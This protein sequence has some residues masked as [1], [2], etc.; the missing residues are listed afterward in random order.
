MTLKY[1][2]TT[3]IRDNLLIFV[4]DPTQ[5]E[6]TTIERHGTYVEARI[7]SFLRRVYAFPLT[8]SAVDPYLTELVVDLTTARLLRRYFM[9][10]PK[11]SETETTLED[12]VRQRLLDI[13]P[14]KNNILTVRLSYNL[15]SGY[16]HKPDGKLVIQE[17]WQDDDF[18]S[19]GID[20]ETDWDDSDNFFKMDSQFG[21][22]P[23]AVVDL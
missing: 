13:I 14:N 23:D 20:V 8:P 12:D 5:L 4:K 10:T 15:R 7:D 16:V 9:Q 21:D 17:G 11:K 6:D 19:T 18:S 2:T 1:A 3:E 22:N